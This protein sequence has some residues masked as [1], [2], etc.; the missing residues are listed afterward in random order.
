MLWAA[1]HVVLYDIWCYQIAMFTCTRVYDF[2]LHDIQT[3][4]YH[5]VWTFYYDPSP[6]SRYDV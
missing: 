6:K 4:K 5:L 1:I 3:E 2:D